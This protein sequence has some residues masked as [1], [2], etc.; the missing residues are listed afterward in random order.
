MKKIGIIG[1]LGPLATVDFFN[2]I[3]INTN[4]AND[5]DNVPILIYN[6]PQIPDR[7]KSILY[8][9]ESPVNAIVHTA[10]VLENMGADF[11]AIP[12]N[13]SFYYYE[14]IVEQLRVPLLNMLDLTADY[15]V[16]K[17]LKNVCILGTEGTLKSRIYHDKLKD[18]NIDVVDIDENMTELLSYVIYDVVKKN[19][20]NV[21]ISNFKE[22]LK[23][24]RDENNVDVFVLACTELPILFEHFGLDFNT[25]DPTLLLALESIRLSKRG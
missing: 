17:G 5:Q 11:L 10:K 13:T 8:G 25:V 23:S 12:C 7:T 4:A 2:K 3:V 21:D 24:F 14:Q 20:F 18:R 9:G 22:K 16:D 1:G 6:N 19:D 15:L